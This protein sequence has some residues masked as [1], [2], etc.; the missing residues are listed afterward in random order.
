MIKTISITTD[1]PL[2]REVHITLPADV[3]PG[4]AEIVVVVTPHASSAG[5]QTLG[6]FLN[7]EFFGMWRNRTDIGDSTE[8]ARRLRIEAWSRTS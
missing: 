6:D 3:P 8:F 2:N 4:P 1:I 5:E 7:S